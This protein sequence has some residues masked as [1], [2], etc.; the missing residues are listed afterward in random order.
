MKATNIFFYFTQY[1]PLPEEVIEI[2]MKFLVPIPSNITRSCVCG[3]E[4]GKCCLHSRE[5]C[6]KCGPFSYCE[7]SSIFR[8]WYRDEVSVPFIMR[9]VRSIFESYP[10]LT[11]FS[12][13]D[14][15]RVLC[16]RFCWNYFFL[17]KWN[18]DI[19]EFLS[20]S[21]KSHLKKRLIGRELIAPKPT[22][23]DIEYSRNLQEFLS[24]NPKVEE[25]VK[26]VD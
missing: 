20:L 10:I 6:T 17:M 3:V 11:P 25:I 14:I 9:D 8:Y 4:Y 26:F 16:M 24:Q 18:S 23:E 13:K 22:Q 7:N 15:I 19:S 5:F 21:C 2:I 1:S 12:R